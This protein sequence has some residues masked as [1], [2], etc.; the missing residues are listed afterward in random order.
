MVKIN[1]YLLYPS[2]CPPTTKTHCTNYL[3]LKAATPPPSFMFLNS[4][5]VLYLLNAMLR[6]ISDIF[7]GTE[8]PFGMRQKGLFRPFDLGIR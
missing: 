7:K 8:M 2:L 1:F 3:L 5:F 4:Q 6:P